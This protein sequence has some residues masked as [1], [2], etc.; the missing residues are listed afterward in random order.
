MARYYFA[1]G[2]LDLASEQYQMALTGQYP[3]YIMY[4]N[5]GSIALF[6]GNLEKAKEYLTKAVAIEPKARNALNT[7]AV[8]CLKLNDIRK[9]EE[10]F[11]RSVQADPFDTT[12]QY[13]LQYFLRTKNMKGSLSN[14]LPIILR[15]N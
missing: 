7:L 12:A 6:Q 3:D 14:N 13:N 9:A 2:K 11:R 10:Y 1:H 8:V 5:L 15:A 4:S